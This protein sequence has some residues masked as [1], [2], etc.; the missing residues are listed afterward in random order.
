MTFF[1]PLPCFSTVADEKDFAEFDGRARLS[2]EL[3]DLEDGAVL[4][5]ILFAARGD[6][7]VH[8]DNSGNPFETKALSPVP[9]RREAHSTYALKAGQTI[10]NPLE[11]MP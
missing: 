11:S 4:D 8:R 2:V 6:D 9:F 7:R 1:S 3:F 5:P 10:N